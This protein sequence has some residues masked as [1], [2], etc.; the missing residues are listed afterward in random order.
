VPSPADPGEL[1]AIV[2]FVA[3]QQARPDRRISY[4]GTEAEGI[5]AELDGLEPPWATTARV[6]RAGA[7][8]TGAVVVEWDEDLG[9]S[10]VIGPWA[11]G[12]GAAWAGAAGMLLDA[13][14][15][16]APATVTRHEMSGEVANRRLA[17][18]AAARGWSAGEVNHVLLADAG[19]AAASSF[20]TPTPPPLSLWTA[21][22]TGAASTA[23][24]TW[25]S[26][27]STRPRAVPASA[28]GSSSRSAAS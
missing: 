13:A 27:P 18:L 23:R 28:A 26:W 4:V 9:R 24:A 19:C 11:A 25:T 6:L 15:A 3:A 16:Q 12:D 5:G 1:D 14:L 22:S 8:I 10:W 2:A 17:D 21:R 20:P 7:A